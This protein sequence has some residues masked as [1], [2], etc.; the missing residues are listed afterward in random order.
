MI[1]TIFTFTENFSMILS[2]IYTSKTGLKRSINEDFSSVYEME[3]GLLSVVCDGL[4]G[5]VAGDVASRL[6]GETI[7]E[8]YRLNIQEE[9]LTRINSA[10]LKANERV[11]AIANR[12]DQYKGMATTAVVLF[13]HG[14][15]ACWGHVGDSRIYLSKKDSIVQLTKDHSLVQKLVD[16][17]YISNKDAER[18]PQKNVIVRAVGD[19]SEL[20]V[21]FDYLYMNEDEEWKFFLCSDGVSNVIEKEEICDFLKNNDLNEI[22]ELLSRE[23]EKRGAPDNYSF[24][25]IANKHS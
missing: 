14:N 21:D 13:V 3:D 19:K 22:S 5:N 23:V 25:I 9:Y 4:G 1:N 11:R 10:I 24:V 15:K 16:D 8:Y 12:G 2:Y 7:A 18:H 17:G 20:V 6:A